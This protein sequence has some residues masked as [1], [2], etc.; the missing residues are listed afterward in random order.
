MITPNELSALLSRTWFR[1]VWTI[2]EQALSSK[3]TLLVCGRH[4]ILWDDFSRAAEWWFSANESNIFLNHG[5][6]EPF[7]N[8]RRIRL[9]LNAKNLVLDPVDFL[10]YARDHNSTKPE[11]KIY[12]VFSLL[13]HV[14]LE[15]LD[16]DYTV[17]VAAL[18][19][20]V[21]IAAIARR[22]SLDVFD[23]LLSHTRRPDLP[24]WVP[25]WTAPSLKGIRVRRDVHSTTEP[26]LT[27]ITY[28]L[29]RLASC[30]CQGRF[31]VA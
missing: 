1:R 8:Q 19:E 13:Q 18:C 16:P 10:T 21:T 29:D 20:Q 23:V 27:D 25:D 4:S 9:A 3:R 31:I 14:G 12:G 26:L 11:D 22:E 24:S 6:L 2:Q 15:M 5:P 30:H 28:L 17:P 7:F